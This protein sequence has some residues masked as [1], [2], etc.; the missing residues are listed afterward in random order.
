MKGIIDRILDGKW[1]VILVGKDETEYNVPIE[2]LPLKAKEGSVVSVK[3]EGNVVVSMNLL[4]DET[5]SQKNIIND[6]MNLLKSRQRS[7]FKR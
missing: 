6:K 4:E 3:L 2:K 1:A 7:N 5:N